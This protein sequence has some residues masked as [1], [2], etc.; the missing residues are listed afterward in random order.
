MWCEQSGF[1]NHLFFVVFY[2]V[3]K[4]DK[5][6][7]GIGFYLYRAESFLW[8]SISVVMSSW[9]WALK[10]PAVAAFIF[11]GQ[12]VSVWFQLAPKKQVQFKANDF[13]GNLYQSNLIPSSPSPLLIEWRD[14][15]IRGRKMPLFIGHMDPGLRA[16]AM[17]KNMSLDG[18]GARHN[19]PALFG[20]TWGEDWNVWQLFSFFF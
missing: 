16:V 12:Q 1:F 19:E 8:R 9:V 10:T 11:T 7:R 5:S 4:Y 20:R 14:P 18:M 2:E 13:Q 15:W 3:C 17:E 6:M